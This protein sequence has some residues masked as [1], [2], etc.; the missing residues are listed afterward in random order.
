LIELTKY[1][2]PKGKPIPIDFRSN[3]RWFQHIEIAVSEMDR[4]YQRLRQF[5]VQHSS[6]APQRI[7]ESNKAAAGIRA[8]Y[9]KDLMANHT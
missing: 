9:F 8:F 7:S 1:L 6:T 5:K 3:D 4:A 2:T